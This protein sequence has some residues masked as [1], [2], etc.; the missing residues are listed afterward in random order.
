M[1]CAVTGWS[2]HSCFW[3]S[4][5]AVCTCGA[6]MT[7]MFA[8]QAAQV[9]QLA[10][11]IFLKPRAVL[12]IC[13]AMFWNQQKGCKLR[14]GVPTLDVFAGPQPH[15]TADKPLMVTAWRVWPGLRRCVGV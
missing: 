2:Y 8:Y 4:K 5:I 7:Q 13:N 14:W 9:F 1:I 11:A 3:L 10:G 12:D 15:W 6:N